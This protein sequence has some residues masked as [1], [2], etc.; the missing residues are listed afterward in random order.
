MEVGKIQYAIREA[1]M[2]IIKARDAMRR[3]EK[4]E[5]A[6]ISG[7]KETAAC[8]RA[9]MDLTRSLAELRK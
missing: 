2:F 4:D 8:R 5:M 7:S 1:G 6:H 9:S 3:L